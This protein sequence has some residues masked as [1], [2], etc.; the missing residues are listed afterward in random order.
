MYRHAILKLSQLG[1]IMVMYQFMQTTAKR[2]VS[3]DTRAQ[4][5]R[6]RYEHNPYVSIKNLHVRLYELK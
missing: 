2:Q 3:D 6:C 5:S 4:Y 1:V